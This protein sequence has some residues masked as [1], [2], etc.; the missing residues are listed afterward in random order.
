M[1]STFLENLYYNLD[2]KSF[3]VTG[4]A[5]FLGANVVRELLKSN[6]HVTGV[7]NLLTG[8]KENLDRFIDDP[9]F[10][11]KELD[12]T[13]ARFPYFPFKPFDAVIHLAAIPRSAWPNKQEVIDVNIGGTEYAINVANKNQARLIYASSCCAAFPTMNEYAWS[14]AVGETGALSQSQFGA[15]ALR[16]SN[17]YGLGQSEEGAEPNVL[18]SWRRQA[19]ETGQIRLDAPGSQVRDFIHVLDAARATVWAAVN[20]V[21]DGRAVDICTG[22]QTPLALIA[23]EFEKQGFEIIDGPQRPNDPH[24]YPQDPALAKLLYNFNSHRHFLSFLEDIVVV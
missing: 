5:G 16:Y 23:E 6:A 21:G 9:R 2:G 4:A 12:I 20:P 18:A 8:K 24:I 11:F 17:I 19:R 3:L 15:V 1:E 7:D 22:V 14:K 13:E 10:D